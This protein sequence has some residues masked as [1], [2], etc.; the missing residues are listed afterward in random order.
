MKIKLIR[1]DHQ[2]NLNF[3]LLKQE[4]TMVKRFIY[5]I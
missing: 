4:I 5:G 1:Y 2:N 3:D